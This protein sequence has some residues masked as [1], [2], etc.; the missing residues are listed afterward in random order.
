MDI[1]PASLSH[2]TQIRLI[3]HDAVQHLEHPRYSKAKKDAW[4]SKPRSIK[5][6]HNQLKKLVTF[7]AI[8][9]DEVLGFIALDPHF[10]RLGYIHYL[11]VKPS[12]Q[13]KGV[14]KKLIKQIV[15]YAN[16]SGFSSL[17]VDASYASKSLFLSAGFTVI[18]PSY[19]YI[20]G[21]TL[22]GFSMVMGI[23]ANPLPFY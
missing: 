2:A 20:K 22:N 19:H 15:N 14:A 6:W 12:A 7:V 4:S 18:N 21:Q 23:K 1:I 17:S 8:D 16:V 5:Y 9:N 3:Y 10:N 13:G 11:Y